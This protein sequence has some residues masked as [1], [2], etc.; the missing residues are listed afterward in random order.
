MKPIEHIRKSLFEVSQTVF[1][2]IA[3]TTQASVSRWE[4]GAQ[5]PSH[6]ELE[7]IRNEAIQRGIDWDD[8]WFFETPTETDNQSAR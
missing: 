8:R 3:G 1:A 4:Q 6:S 7:R 2:E 5:E